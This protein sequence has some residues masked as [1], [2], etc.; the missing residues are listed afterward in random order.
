M[1][2]VASDLTKFKEDGYVVVRGVLDWGQD[3]KPVLHEYEQLLDGLVD[4]WFGQ[5]LLHSK[6]AELPFGDRLIRSVFEAKQ[7]YDSHFD[8]S[9]PQA[10]ITEETPIHTGPAVFDLLRSPRLLDVVEQFIGPEIYCNPVQHTRVKLPESGLPDEARTGLTGRIDWHQDAGVI[11]ADADDTNLLTDWFPLTDST[12]ENGCLAVVPGSH[13]LGLELHCRSRNPLAFNQ[14]AIP[15]HL[16]SDDQVLLSMEP[17]DVLFMHRRTRH[18][19]T[20][21]MSDRIRWSFDLRYQPPGEPTGRRWFP[22]FVARSRCHPESE[23]NDA[24]EWAEMWREAKHQLAGGNDV[25]FNR[26]RQADPRCA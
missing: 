7:P 11:T 15:E 9:L 26:W 18:C 21:N 20:P 10:D 13:R 23:L 14:L 25:T 8:I 2:L 1:Q 12:P 17:G 5:G 4:W 6:Y 24:A 19:G 22:G 3:L 16:M